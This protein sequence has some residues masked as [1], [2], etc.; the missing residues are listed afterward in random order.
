MSKVSVA[1]ALSR[2]SAGVYLPRS[3]EVMVSIDPYTSYDCVHL[4]EIREARSRARLCRWPSDQC[5]E[6]AERSVHFCP[7]SVE[8]PGFNPLLTVPC[9]RGNTFAAAFVSP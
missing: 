3:G 7:R 9:Q 1:V 8:P 6:V 4:F 5:S 2:K